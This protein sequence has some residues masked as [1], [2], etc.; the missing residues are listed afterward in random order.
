MTDMPNTIMHTRSAAVAIGAAAMLA[1]SACND[2]AFL[3]EQPFDFVGPTNFYQS[4]GDALAAVNGAYASLENAAPGGANNYY[5][6]NF[7]MLVEFPGEALTVYLSAT[8]ERSQPDNYTLPTSHSYVYS[9]WQSAYA[10]I[11]RANAVINRVPAIP[12]DTT[13]RNRVVAEAKFLRALH[14]FNLVRLFG[15]VPIFTQE[16]T[17]LD[18]LKVPRATTSDVYAAIV[19]DLQDAIRVLPSSKTYTGAD[20][21]RASRGAAK[22]LLTKVYL[23]RAANGGGGA[24]DNQAALDMARQVVTDADYSLVANPGTLYDLVDGLLQEQNTEV[25]FDIQ[26][27]RQAGLGGNLGNFFA[28]RN[29]SW[30]ASQNG[31]FE[32]E[33]PFF[34]S[35][36]DTDKRK[37]VTFV[38]SFPNKSGVATPYLTTS[39]AS[40]AYGA[41]TPYLKKFIDPTLVSGG[42]EEPNYIVLRYADLLLMQAEAANEVAG[43]TAEAYT[44]VNAVRTRAGVPNMTPGLSKQLFKDSVFVERRKELV[45]EGPHAYFDSQ[46]NWDWAKARVEANMAL[47]KAGNFRLSKYPKAQVTLDDKFKLMPIPQRARDLNPLLTQNP[48]W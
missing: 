28:P 41:D 47:G 46:R 25:I 43:P 45:G 7:T 30:G 10:G 18:S 13:L 12:M 26:N 33:Q 29:S 32:A 21:G 3:T 5:G 19:K 6:R 27:I 23:Q 35:F 15:G 31:A 42:Q 14:Y 4:A 20:I 1:L 16:T 36:T 44:A 34:D 24:A 9:T 22:T 11:N 2:K 38:L 40:T 37:A 17:S 48:G 39:T 8:N